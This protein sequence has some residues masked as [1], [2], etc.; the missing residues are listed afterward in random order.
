MS[1]TL[2]ILIGLVAGLAVGVAVSASGSA[3]LHALPAYIEPI[4][5]IWVSALRMLVI[6]LVVSAILIGV[7]SLPDSR[8]IGRVGSRALVTFLLVLLAAATYSVIVAPIALSQLT[9]DPVAAAS[10]KAHAESASGDAMQSAQKLTTFT[11]W[12]V[13]LVPTNPVK[14]AADGAML[15]LIVFTLLFG[16]AVTQLGAESRAHLMRVVVGVYEASLLLMGWVLVAAPL[17]VFALS[18][19]LATRLGLA[20]A[21]AVAYFVGA[22]STMC[23]GFIAALYVVAWLV[24]KQDMRAFARAIAP[25]Q[26]V[27]FSSR[28]SLVSLPALLQAAAELR[29]PVSIRSFYLPLAAATFRTG[30]AIHIPFAVL[31]VARLYGVDLS[32]QQLVTVVLTAVLTTFTVPGIP[33]GTIIVM[34]PVLMAVGL[35]VGA[36]GLLLGVDTIPDM[37]RTT[38]H[39]TSDMAT[40]SILARLEPA[41]AAIMDGT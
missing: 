10:L 22:V 6:P 28:S 32:S 11:Q 7:T 19:P 23:I 16:L 37:F 35:P 13:E 12:F 36:I 39:I 5:T 20:A 30:S 29:L 1:L 14:A 21:G 24:G 41:D 9:I 18:V 25:A 3:T 31:F 17:G 38:T 40:A 26:A 27:A 8:S 34:V 15:P 2:K 4:G 33:G